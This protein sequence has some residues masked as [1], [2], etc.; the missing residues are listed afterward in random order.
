MNSIK[1]K[2]IFFIF[3]VCFTLTNSHPKINSASEYR[4]G[5][6][7]EIP[8]KIS[9]KNRLPIPNDIKR[10]L[11]YENPSDFKDF[12]IVLDLEN[13]NHEV[14]LYNL[15]ATQVMFVEGMNKAINTLTT[16]L[17]VKKPK[18]NY[19]FYDE[20]LKDIHINYWNTSKIGNTSK[21]GFSEQ[22]I[23]FMLFVRFGNKSEMGDSVLASAGARYLER[24]T[25]QPLIG[26]VNINRDVD[27]SKNNSLNYFESIIIHEFTHAL[28]FAN[29]FFT[30]YFHNIFKKIDDSGIE[31]VYINSSKVVQT[32]RKYF[33]CDSIEG[34]ELE[35][36]GGSGTVGSHWE[37]RIL[38]GDYMNGVIYTADQVISE[39]TLALLEDSGYYK[40]NYYTGGLMQYGK[41]KGCDFVYQKCVN[42]GKINPK[43]SNEFFDDID[44]EYTVYDPSCSSSRQS[45]AYHVF[46]I[47]QELRQE[48]RYF[49]T[50]ELMRKI[51]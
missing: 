4:C 50:Y 7:K 10:R 1:V 43:F 6:F 47:Y 15:Q 9:E 35:E 2:V 42:E 39:F 26:I 3:V 41:N 14:E 34:V 5:E 18:Y 29:N 22:G 13:F 30:K 21:N 28:G 16:L 44:G 49:G 25:G 36:S 31:R 23:D 38:L 27:Y 45:R 32:A 17:K 20:Q 33:N 24:D 40:A 12:N 37:A 46:Y 8:I 48:Y 51:T 11:D 19:I